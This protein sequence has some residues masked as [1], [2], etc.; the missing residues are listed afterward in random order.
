[1]PSKEASWEEEVGLVLARCDLMRGTLLEPKAMPQVEM[2]E[3]HEGHGR[4]SNDGIGLERIGRVH[5][6]L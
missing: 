6:V 4:D 2:A 3:G 1:M 5:A